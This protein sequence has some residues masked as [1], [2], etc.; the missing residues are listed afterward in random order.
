MQA[1]RVETAKGDSFFYCSMTCATK[2]NFGIT[3]GAWLMQDEYDDAEFCANCEI[4]LDDQRRSVSVLMGR[5]VPC[6]QPARD[7]KILA[8][9]NI[10]L[11]KDVKMCHAYLREVAV[12]LTEIDAKHEMSPHRCTNLIYILEATIKET[13]G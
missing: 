13:E 9:S 1:F 6:G 11:L 5:G 2:H 10:E 7:A 12:F 4:F 3:E 8:E